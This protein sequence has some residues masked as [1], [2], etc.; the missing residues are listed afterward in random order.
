M[1]CP[2]L[3]V[4]P[5]GIT[6]G[7]GGLTGSICSGK[8]PSPTKTPV[9]VGKVNSVVGGLPVELPSWG[10]RGLWLSLIPIGLWLSSTSLS[11]ILRAVSV[12]RPFPV[13]VGKLGRGLVVVVVLFLLIIGP[14]PLAILGKGGKM[15]CILPSSELF[16]LSGQGNVS[17]HVW[18]PFI[19]QGKVPFCRQVWFPFLDQ[20]NVPLCLPVWLRSSSLRVLFIPGRGVKLLGS[21]VPLWLFQ[22]GQLWWSERFRTTTCWNPL[23]S[24]P[25]SSGRIPKARGTGKL[26]F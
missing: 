12:S 1:S 5:E 13:T 14:V 15:G 9:G 26:R 3:G 24:G 11:N 8:P 7:M 20:G 6:P 25:N 19:G 21:W 2:C 17:F 18:F 22:P 4:A 16:P 10:R 23:D